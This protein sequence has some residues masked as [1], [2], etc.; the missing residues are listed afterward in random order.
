MSSTISSASSTKRNTFHHCVPTWSDQD[1]MA[2]IPPHWLQ[3]EPAPKAFY[4]ITGLVISVIGLV[5]FF[6]NAVVVYNNHIS[7]R[8]G[9]RSNDM[10]VNLALCDMLMAT[11]VPPMYAV[12]SFHSKWMF[13]VLGCQFHGFVGSLCGTAAIMTITAMAID[14]CAVI[15]TPFERIRPSITAKRSKSVLYCIWVYS[16]LWAV[17]PLLPGFPSYVPAGY[18]VTCSFNV[19]DTT[20][21][22]RAYISL[23][24]IGAYFLPLMIISV[25]YGKILS[26]IVHRATLLR[27]LSTTVCSHKANSTNERAARAQQI[28]SAKVSV[29]ILLGWLLAWTPYCVVALLGVF[30]EKDYLT[31]MAYHLPSVFAKT[32]ALYNPI[33]YAFSNPRYRQSVKTNLTRCWKGDNIQAHYGLV[34]RSTD[35]PSDMIPTNRRVNFRS[36]T[37]SSI[38][39]RWNTHERYAK[40]FV[41]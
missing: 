35:Y 23:M 2:I 10:V 18:L 39:Q 24:C 34:R 13:G 32:A 12:S 38:E 14:R 22:N 26:V 5:A 1:L 21:S 29:C 40:K 19:L 11:I 27:T 15:C 30:G 33:I 4:V 31:P 25:S 7:K 6:G 36:P 8:G 17:I 37:G 41:H 3:F 28:K 9:S 16:F 20:T